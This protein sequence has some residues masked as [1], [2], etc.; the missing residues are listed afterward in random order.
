MAICTFLGYRAVYEQDIYERLSDAVYGL[1]RKHE[2]VEFLFHCHGE[3][4]DMCLAAVLEAKQ[5]YPQKKITMTWAARADGQDCADVPACMID[6]IIVP[7]IPEQDAIRA[8]AKRERWL[9]QHATHLISYVYFSL[10][11]PENRHYRYAE[12]LGLTIRDVTCP[13]TAAY[14]A[15]SIGALPERERFIL[16]RIDDGLTQKQAG[17]LLG[18]SGPVARQSLMRSC[19]DLRKLM[20]A[21]LQTAREQNPAPPV[22]C[23]IFALGRATGDALRRFE[24][25]T[26]FLAR[27]YHVTRFSIAAEYCHTP[28]ADALLRLAG[29]SLHQGV[30]FTAVTHYPEMPEDGRAALAERF[31]PLC[32]RVENIDTGVRSP[33]AQM[34]RTVKTMMGTSDF[35][36]CNLSQSALG[37]SIR[38]HMPRAKGLKLLDI[39]KGYTGAE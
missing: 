6:K 38:K 14:I 28:Y 19:R 8:H 12:R 39:S 30:Q 9:I 33:R 16:Q 31:A 7:P 29:S 21:R 11:A 20:K 17:E 22:T 13:D 2:E 34:L 23:G 3:F 4:Y 36:I 37:E 10:H 27:T 15:E 32:Q 1:V 25:A 5:H 24:Q 26:L 35:C 18:V